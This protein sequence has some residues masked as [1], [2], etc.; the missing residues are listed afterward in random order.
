MEVNAVIMILMKYNGYFV[1]KKE[2]ETEYQKIALLLKSTV[3]SNYQ[4]N[5]LQY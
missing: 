1:V 4:I 2:N 5:I 3:Y